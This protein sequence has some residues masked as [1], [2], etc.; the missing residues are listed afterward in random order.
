MYFYSLFDR[1]D[2]IPYLTRKRNKE[3]T[4]VCVL[5]SVFY[6]IDVMLKIAQAACIYENRGSIDAYTL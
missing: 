2:S 4:R 5:H 1:V 6:K 3:S